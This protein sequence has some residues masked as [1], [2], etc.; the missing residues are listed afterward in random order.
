[1]SVWPAFPP[2]A[3]CSSEVA[4]SMGSLCKNKVF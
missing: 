3:D 4:M 2:T 1:V